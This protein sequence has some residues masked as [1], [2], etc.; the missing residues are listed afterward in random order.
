MV[1]GTSSRDDPLPAPLTDDAGGAVR[2]LF[3]NRDFRHYWSSAASFGVGI[4]AYLTAMGWTALELT[5]SSFAV[6]MVN[7]VYFLPFFVFA[8]PGGILA[9]TVDR[10]RTAIWARVACGAAAVVLTVL[11]ALGSLSYPWLLALSAFVGTTIIAELASRQAYVAQIVG[12]SMVGNAFALTAFQGGITRVIGPIVAGWAIAAWGDAGGYGFFFATNLLFLA[13]FTRI[14]A[15]GVPAPREPEPRLRT[16]TSGFRYLG[17]NQQAAAVVLMSVLSGAVGWVYLAMMPIVARDVL[18]GGAVLAGTLSTAVGV[19]SLP[20]SVLLSVRSRT[21]GEGRLYA[22]GLGLWAAGIIVFG[23]AG[24]V[25]VALP[26]LFVSG[27]GFTMNTVLSQTLLLKL[28]EPAFHGRV[29]GLLTLTWGANI[30]GT[31]T[32]G[33][34]AE[35]LGVQ[36]VVVASGLLIVAVAVA[37]FGRNRDLLAV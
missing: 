7:V 4:W 34:L 13:F 36:T 9:D 15:S 37:V 18:G 26:A 24:S 3:R 33:A 25:A 22:L 11:A 28:V 17:E 19:G 2:V 29:L 14:R 20:S 35:T 23:L 21:G 6:S 27:L 16:F 8:I 12:P 10:R 32:A 31:L 1:A 5:D 30:I